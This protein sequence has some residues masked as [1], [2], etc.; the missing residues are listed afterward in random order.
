MLHHA[1]DACIKANKHEPM[2][3]VYGSPQELEQPVV[4][5]ERPWPP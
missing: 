3:V 5:G 1:A 4:I 2:Q